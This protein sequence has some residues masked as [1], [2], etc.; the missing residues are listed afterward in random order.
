MIH[1]IGCDIVNVERIAKLVQSQGDRFV[2]R[3]LTNLEKEKFTKITDLTLQNRYLA[4]RFA[5]KEALAKALG[6]GFGSAI[7]FNSISILNNEMGA[8]YITIS[9]EYMTDKLCNM[10]FQ[11]S[12]SDDWPFAVAFVMISM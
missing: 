11:I 2:N 6:T 7:A 9:E 8:P 10:Q 4:K 5:G 1:G 3:I 12:L